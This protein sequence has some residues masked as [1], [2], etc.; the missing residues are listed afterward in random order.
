M[1]A[2]PHFL[3]GQSALSCIVQYSRVDDSSRHRIA[4]AVVRGGASFFI[5]HI[6]KIKRKKKGA[7]F[8]MLLQFQDIVL[9]KY[10]LVLVTAVS[11]CVDPAVFF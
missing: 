6:V 3:D 10:A 1:L 2:L 9:V 5:Q 8:C 4:Q 11:L 7:S